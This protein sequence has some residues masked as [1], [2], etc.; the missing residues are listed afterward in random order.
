MSK[1]K[2]VDNV[3]QPKHYMVGGVET[4]EVIESKMGGKDSDWVKGY[5]LGNALKY[6]TRA[7]YKG[8]MEEDLKKAQYYINRLVN[9]FSDTQHEN[10]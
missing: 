10:N 8:K 7:H 9:C 3:N 5:Y 2:P 1:E 4:I 6:L